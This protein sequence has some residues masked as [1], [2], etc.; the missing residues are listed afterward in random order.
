MDFTLRTSGP[1]QPATVDERAT[2]ERHASAVRAIHNAWSEGIARTGRGILS[3]QIH[4]VMDVGYADVLG[5]SPGGMRERK[6]FLRWGLE[7]D[8]IA[9][10]AER[11]AAYDTTRIYLALVADRHSEGWVSYSLFEIEHSSGDSALILHR[12]YIASR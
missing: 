1:P 12:S 4:W 9:V 2:V 5:F 11:V 3:W 7:A 8:D 6:Q 10:I